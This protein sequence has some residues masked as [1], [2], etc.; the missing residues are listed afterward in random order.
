M[1]VR[2]QVSG[3]EVEV[4]RREVGDE[5]NSGGHSFVRDGQRILWE[6]YYDPGRSIRS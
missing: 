5:D 2:N 6:H 1:D 3:K 4:S